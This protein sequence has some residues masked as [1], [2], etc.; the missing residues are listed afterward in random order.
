MSD[1]K[2]PNFRTQLD[3][4]LE[5]LAR[6]DLKGAETCYDEEGR[7]AGERRGR[8]VAAASFSAVGQ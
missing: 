5:E 1:I 2:R 7:H 4:Q 6:P 3:E 8:R